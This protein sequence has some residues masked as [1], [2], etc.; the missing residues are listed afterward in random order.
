MI[1]HLL[2]K[3]IEEFLLINLT[4]S[5]RS[6]FFNKWLELHLGLNPIERFTRDQKLLKK[7]Q[8]VSFVLSRRSEK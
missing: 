2:S 6:F 7:Q 3:E 4:R 8:D 5:I 1:I